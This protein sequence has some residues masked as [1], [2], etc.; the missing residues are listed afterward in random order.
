MLKLYN[1]LTRTLEPFKPVHAGEARVYSCGPTV[2][3]YP[4]IGNMRA[5][6]LRRRAGA[7]AEL[8][9]LHAHPRH[10]HHRRR[11]SDRRRRRRRGQDGEDGARK[12]AIDLGYRAPLHR[13]VLGGYQG[14]ER[15]RAGQVVDRD[16][17][18]AADDRLREVHR[19]AA[20]LRTGQRAVLRHGFGRGLRSSRPPR[21]R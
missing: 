8:E 7:H 15:A 3:N 14:A 19:R 6:G 16:R 1:S 2:Y 4:H 9:G 5:Y 17:L 13:G 21:H 11:P 20:L 10:Q 18:R 12:S